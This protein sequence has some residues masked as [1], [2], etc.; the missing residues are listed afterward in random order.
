M[1]R[2]SSTPLPIF[3]LFKNLLP[4]KNFYIFVENLYDMENWKLIDE[5]S[6]YEVNKEGQVRNVKTGR[7]LKPFL[8]HN[9]Y[10]KVSYGIYLEI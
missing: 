6:K 2:L 8:S 1:S 9:G 4:C 10:L 3:F 5:D 7:L